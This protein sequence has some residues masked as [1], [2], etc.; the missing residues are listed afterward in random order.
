MKYLSRSVEDQLNIWKDEEDRLPLLIRGARQVGKSSL[1][2][3]FGRQF[4]YYLELNLEMNPEMT[5]V[6][7]GNLDP[8]R[9]CTDLSLIYNTPIEPGKT[10][11]FIDEIQTSLPALSSLR[12]FYEQYPELHVIAAGS[13]LEFA[14]SELPSFGV[15]RI[16][17]LFL[18][19]FSFN[20]FLH[21]MGENKL[22]AAIQNAM[23]ENPLSELVHKKA[24]GLFKRFLIIGGMPKVVSYYVETGD[25]LECQQ[26]LDDLVLSFQDDFAK[27]KKRISSFVIRE[28]FDAVVAQNAYKFVFTKAAPGLNRGQVKLCLELLSMAG[29]IYPV[30]HSSANGIPLGA[31]INAK[32]RKYIVFDTGI[33]QRILGLDLRA[34]LMDNEFE[35]IN[36]GSIAELFIGLELMKSSSK[37]NILY[38]WQ[39][40]SKNSQAEVDYLVQMN[41]RILPIEVKSG[42]KGSMQSLYLFLNEKKIE[43]G[44]RVSQENF[45]MYNNIKVFPLYALSNI[46]AHPERW[47]Y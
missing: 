30:T 7:E 43:M 9:I 1:V 46:V 39:R 44:I 23:S 12:F 20:E 24:L 25:L 47:S 11:L 3:Q 15:G 26:V 2:K 32:F 42:T 21:A 19:P 28:V 16:R 5:K 8:H 34:F 31:Q 14:L 13:L 17:S 45:S 22:L 40:E 33:Y 35:S 29:L 10:L 38:Y 36:K 6:F 41:A 18:Y 27:Y 37:R 4:Q